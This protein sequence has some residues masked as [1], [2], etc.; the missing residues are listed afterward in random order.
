MRNHKSAKA[1]A[2]L[3]TRPSNSKK[4]SLEFSYSQIGSEN[5][6]CNAIFFMLICKR[7]HWVVLQ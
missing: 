6:S 3:L 4:N 7:D 1:T 2:N 5:F